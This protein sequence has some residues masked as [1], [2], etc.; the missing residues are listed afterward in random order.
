MKSVLKRKL[1]GGRWNFRR[2]INVQCRRLAL[3]FQLRLPFP[4][5]LLLPPYIL[6]DRQ[7]MA[8]EAQDEAHRFFVAV[9]VGAGFHAPSNE[10]ALRSAMKRACLAAAVV[11]RKVC[12][13][14]VFPKDRRILNF[15]SIE[16]ETIT[17][18][19]VAFLNPIECAKR[20]RFIVRR[21]HRNVFLFNVLLECIEFWRSSWDYSHLLFYFRVVSI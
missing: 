1:K 16:I 10:K 13:A 7:R 8:A 3:R 17:A 2:F 20:I 11:L 18:E 14:L 5:E 12:F 19:S 15:L 21:D 6:F 9:H 4:P